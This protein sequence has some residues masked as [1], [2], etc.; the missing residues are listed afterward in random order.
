M[1]V[2]GRCVK[3]LNPFPEKE[4]RGEKGKQNYIM[5]A[6]SFQVIFFIFLKLDFEF[7]RE[8]GLCYMAP[9]S[10]ETQTY[11]NIFSLNTIIPSA[12]SSIQMH[13]K[14]IGQIGQICQI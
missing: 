9:V 13:P 4:H 3:I 6:L 10:K 5:V 1:E 14:C 2:Y 7:K 11:C 8:M 12:S